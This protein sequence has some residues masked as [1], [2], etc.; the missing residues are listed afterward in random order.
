M[1]SIETNIKDKANVIHLNIQ[2]EI[3]QLYASRFNARTVPTFVMLNSKSEVAWTMV[4]RV[5]PNKVYDSL[6]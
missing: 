6:K 1:D 4:G 2:S 5:D 3:G